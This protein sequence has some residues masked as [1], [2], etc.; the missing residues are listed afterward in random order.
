[1]VGEC[2]QIIGKTYQ[3]GHMKY[4]PNAEMVI[5]NDAGHT[6]MGEKPEACLKIIDK[7]FNEE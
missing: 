5:I 1:M 2:N 7:Y 4:F 6:M 3:E